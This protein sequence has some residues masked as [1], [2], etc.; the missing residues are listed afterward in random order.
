MGPWLFSTERLAVRPKT[1]AD[2]EAL[3]ERANTRSLKV[4][5]KLGMQLSNV[6]SHA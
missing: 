5:D 1:L 6:L 4:I 2:S 3:T